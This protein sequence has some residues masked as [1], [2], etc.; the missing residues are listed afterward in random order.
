MKY[1]ILMQFIP[2]ND[3]IWVEKLNPDDPIWIFD[4]LAEAEVKKAELEAADPGRGY[5]IV[6]VDSEN[7]KLDV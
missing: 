3:Q 2:G 6:S 5:K 7:N 4:T 1:L